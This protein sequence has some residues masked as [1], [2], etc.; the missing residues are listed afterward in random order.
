MSDLGIPDVSCEFCD[1]YISSKDAKTI[2]GFWCCDACYSS[3]NVCKFCNNRYMDNYFDE[4]HGICEG[5]IDSGDILYCFNCDTY[6]ITE[7]VVIEPQINDFYLV[8]NVCYDC[9]YEELIP[10]YC[11]TDFEDTWGALLN[12]NGGKLI[13]DTLSEEQRAL[14]KY[15]YFNYD[16]VYYVPTGTAFHSVNWCYTL[17]YSNTI[18]QCTYDEATNADLTPCSKCVWFQ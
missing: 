14:V 15:P 4:E 6:K 12:A 1:K 10:Y 2:I 17:E 18:Y 9:L 16:A 8:D 7:D 11:G 5:C 3:A 13:Y